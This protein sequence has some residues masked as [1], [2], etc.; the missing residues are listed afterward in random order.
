[1]KPIGAMSSLE[2]LSTAVALAGLVFIFSGM[3]NPTVHPR[4]VVPEQNCP[5]IQVRHFVGSNLK[6]GVKVVDG[7]SERL[8]IKIY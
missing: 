1:M 3:Y 7:C 8:N 6:T 5:D 4:P 2:F